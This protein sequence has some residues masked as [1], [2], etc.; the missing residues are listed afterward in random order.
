MVITNNSLEDEII[1]RDESG[2]LKTLTKAGIKEV[3]VGKEKKE[4]VVS[5]NFDKEDEKEIDGF[6]RKLFKTTSPINFNQTVDE[7]IRKSG[8]S[9]KDDVI[10]KR[11][12]N[13]ATARLRDIRD[14]LE[15]KSAIMHPQNLGGLGLDE[16]KTE[17]I[18]DLIEEK[19]QILI[20]QA[21]DLVGD[22]QERDM[23]DKKSVAKPPIAQRPVL[24]FEPKTEEEK[25]ETK[26]LESTFIN[27]EPKPPKLPDQIKEAEDTSVE[28]RV[29][30][31]TKL[32]GPIEELEKLNLDDFRRLAKNPR[33]MTEKI[34]EKIE[35]LAKESFSQK[36]KGVKAW[37]RSPLNQL[38]L[39][40]GHQ[41]LLTEGRSLEEILA[42]RSSQGQPSLTVGEFKAIMDFNKK[43]RH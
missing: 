15:T 1:I 19:L 41:C 31:S 30:Y 36:I 33:E 39:A 9:F 10:K 21:Q 38:Y 29:K 7:I 20:R 22:R 3:F 4:E 26:K 32:V 11:F 18:L 2:E 23:I 42:E 6:R 5:F 27:E 35:L 14:R 8:L 34:N 43:L 16:Q 37:Y 17:K 12:I 28:K 25:V 24:I 40:V 13:I